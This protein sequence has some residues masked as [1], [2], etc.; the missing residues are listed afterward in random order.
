MVT[1]TS[2]EAQETKSSG[3]TKY[4]VRM[5]AHTYSIRALYQILFEYVEIDLVFH[6]AMKHEAMEA[7]I[8][9]VHL[10]IKRRKKITK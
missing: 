1:D 10:R 3:T 4:N 6:K 7:S 2:D 8:Q 9:L 5:T